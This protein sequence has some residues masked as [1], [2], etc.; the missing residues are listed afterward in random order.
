MKTQPWYTTLGDWVGGFGR[1]RRIPQYAF[2]WYR[3]APMT[4]MGDAMFEHYEVPR[5]ARWA[6]WNLF[7]TVGEGAKGVRL[8]DHGATWAASLAGRKEW[9][10]SPPGAMYYGLE[11]GKTHSEEKY[12]A[13]RGFRHCTQQAG[14]MVMLPEGWAH[15]VSLAVLCVLCVLTGGGVY[16]LTD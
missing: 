11:R 2:S 16:C 4:A 5:I 12:R 15:A 13:T 9:Y 7:Y 1:Y 3:D 10:V 6:S 14:D 8:H